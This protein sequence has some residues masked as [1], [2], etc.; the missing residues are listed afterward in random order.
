VHGNQKKRTPQRAPLGAALPAHS[1]R[2]RT[3]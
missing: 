2:N 3:E 1:N